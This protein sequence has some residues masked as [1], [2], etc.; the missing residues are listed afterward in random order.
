MKTVSQI[1]EMRVKNSMRAR[2]NPIKT[3]TPNSL[4]QMLD[5]FTA[6]YLKAAAMT[7]DAIERRDDVIQGVSA[8][9]KKSV[10]RLNWEI[11]PIDD[12]ELAQQQKSALKHF[13]NNI[14]ATN[15][16]DNNEKGGIA[17]LIRQ[18]MDAV[19]KKYAVHEI[20]FKPTEHS[21]TKFSQ[22]AGQ[23]CLAQN[24]SL[25]ATFRFVPLW[26]FEN[27]D[28]SL[29]F[30]TNECANSGIALEEGAW[31]VTVGDGL[32]EACSIAYLFKHLP[33]R[34]W[35]VYC[36]RNGMPG[37][38]GITDA[39]PHSE[40]W[41][42]ARDAVEDFGAEFNALMSKGTD[43]EAIDLT[44]RGEL[45]YPALIDRMDR[46]ISALWRGSDL[47]T[48]SRSN[49]A[50]ASLQTDESELLEEDDA[51][52]ISETLNEQVDKYVIKY[53][54]GDVPVLAYFRL[55]P[56]TRR[57]ITSELNLYREL[58]HMGMPLSI[59]DV[60]ERFG[61]PTPNDEDTLLYISNDN[62]E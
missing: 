62:N 55:L 57:N 20:I 14:H 13:Y 45:P 30:L 56:K 40:Q 54:F 16:C 19:G 39:A 27:H 12:S 44:T 61:I 35:L 21:D 5:A 4:S 49:G 22:N 17:L 52:M 43:I 48:L 28:G 41:E 8:K 34:D 29:K 7:W 9:R 59:N 32:M 42:A 2:F 51:N 38:K 15:A 11:L 10:A 53:L 50:G 31:M 6:G 47:A 1:S 24:M 37:V 36:E 58:Y 26:F 18:M 33:L 60:R 25:T 3:L 23:N 46:A